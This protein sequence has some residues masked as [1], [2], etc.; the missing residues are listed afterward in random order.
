MQQQQQ[1][2]AV[3]MQL[4]MQTSNALQWES[5]M[6]QQ[7]QHPFQAQEGIPEASSSELHAYISLS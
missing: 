3:S 6:E 4:Q 1:L 7:K 2:N 5:T